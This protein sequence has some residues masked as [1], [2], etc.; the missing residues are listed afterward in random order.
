MIRRQAQ[1]LA[2]T[3]EPVQRH[4]EPGREEIQGRRHGHGY[5][6]A[7]NQGAPDRGERL[8][9]PR[10]VLQ[11]IPEEQRVKRFARQ[12][13]RNQR[14]LDDLEAQGFPGMPPGI[15]RDLKALHRPAQRTHLREKEPRAA[16]DLAESSPPAHLLAQQPIQLGRPS[17]PIRLPTGRQ[18]HVGSLPMGTH[19]V[20]ALREVLLRIERRDLGIRR[21]REEPGEPALGAA[22]SLEQ[23][24][25]KIVAERQGT[26]RSMPAEGTCSGQRLAGPELSILHAGAAFPAP[27]EG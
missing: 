23:T 9:R 14:A 26:R 22:H 27:S 12:P 11:H 4:P 1:R 3:A 16:T 2:P 13:S 21:H 7:G 6:T 8:S 17:A 18:L 24:T 5:G 10:Q 19:L 25:T 20:R 15:S